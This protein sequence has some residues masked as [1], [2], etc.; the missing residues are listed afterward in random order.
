MNVKQRLWFLS[1]IYYKLES[2]WLESTFKHPN[3]FWTAMRKVKLAVR[4]T[5]KILCNNSI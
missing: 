1:S 5:Q 4:I 2:F 3:L